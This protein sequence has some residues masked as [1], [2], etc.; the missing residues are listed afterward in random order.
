MSK[1]VL[2]FDFGTGNIGVAVGNEETGTAQA[3]RAVRAVNG[4]PDMQ[5]LTQIVNEWQPDYMVV[6]YP[7]NMDGTKEDMSKRAAK[8]G[9]KIASAFSLPVYFKDERLSSAEAKDEIFS[10]GGGYRAL[11]RNKGRIDAAAAKIILEGFFETGGRFGEC[12]LFEP[13]PVKKAEKQSGS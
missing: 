11:V 9:R 5:A 3:L 8:F 10:Y 13:Q 7:L 4:V 2:A 1:R 12:T 6:G